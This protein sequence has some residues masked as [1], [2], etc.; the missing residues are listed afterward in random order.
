[1]SFKKNNYTVIK[2]AIS[3]ELA[4]YVYNCFLLQRKI[5]RTFFDTKYISPYSTE[6]GVWNDPQVLETYSFYSNPIMEVLLEKLKPLMQKETGLTLCETY[7]YCRLYKKG[8]VPKRH[9][10]RMSCEISTTLNLGGDPWP[11]FLEP[12]GKVKQSGV[13]VDLKPGDMLIY[14]GIELEHWREPFT[15]DNCGQV[16]LHYNNVDTQGLDNK[17][18]SRPHL[19]LP[20]EFKT[21]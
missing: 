21:K 3:T 13:E 12:S 7:S 14:R 11:I 15:G 20:S 4:E 19:G 1:M 5:A 16:F 18:D 8:D 2:N 10:D 9:K 6:F 17:F